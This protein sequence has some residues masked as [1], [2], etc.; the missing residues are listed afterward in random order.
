MFKCSYLFVNGVDTYKFKTNDFE[1][2]AIELY[3]FSKD[4]LVNNIKKAGLC[5]HAYDF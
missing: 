3:L 5:G 2:N 4:F 1:I